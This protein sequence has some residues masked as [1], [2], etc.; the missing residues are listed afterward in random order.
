MNCPF[1]QSTLNKVVDKRSVQGTGEIR[2][3]RECLKCRKRFTTYEKLAKVGL[4][5]IKRDG[6]RELF[7]RNKLRS[8]IYKAL[9]KRPAVS[10]VESI[11]NKIESKLR[12]KKHQDI[13]SKVIGR[14]VLG[15]LKKIDKIAY[16]H[17]T[18]VYKKFDDPMDFAKV[19][20]ELGASR[21]DGLQT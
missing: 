17:F 5:V 7:D 21:K 15:E 4:V 18:S 9:E 3:R 20:N 11:T 8:G 12:L 16:L 19:L 6:R 2:R 1:C 14:M 10:E 13:Q